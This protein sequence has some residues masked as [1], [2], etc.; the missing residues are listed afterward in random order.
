MNDNARVPLS[1]LYVAKRRRE[2]RRERI[3]RAAA[4]VL[5]ACASIVFVLINL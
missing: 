4:I 1:L 2:L 5:I 3:A